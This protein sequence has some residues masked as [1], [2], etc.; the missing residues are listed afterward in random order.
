MSII[1]EFA[2]I[3]KTTFCERN[4]NVIDFISI[5]FKYKNFMEIEIL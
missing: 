4:K 2:G 5:P 3:G 1:A